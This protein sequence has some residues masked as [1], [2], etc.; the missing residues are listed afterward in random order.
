MGL[1]TTVLINDI[2]TRTPLYTSGVIDVSA[3]SELTIDMAVTLCSTQG[4]IAFYRINPNNVAE[5]MK[6][7]PFYQ[8]GKYSFDSYHFDLNDGSNPYIVSSFG[9]SIQITIS[10]NRECSG[11][12]S[13]KGK[14][15]L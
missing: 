8:N 1:R 12:I 11:V 10:A 14:G 2:F 3:Y 7:I 5:L 13:M 4:L 15:L 6:E 9:N